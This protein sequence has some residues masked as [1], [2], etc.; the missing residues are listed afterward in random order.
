MKN[1]F[2]KI[3]STALIC[4]FS[5]QA[6]AQ[7]VDSRFY[8]WTVY[9]L[10]EDELHDKQCYIVS[11]PKDS[12]TDHSIRQKP[13]I[14]IA[15]FQRERKEEVSVYGG[16]EYK[17][18]SKIFFVIDD[19]DQYRFPTKG[20]VAWPRSKSEDVEVIQKMLNSSVVRVR[21]DSTIGTFAIDEYSTKGIAKAYSRMREI[22]K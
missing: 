1:G 15:R 16:Y 2:R 12:D 20:D 17:I 4:L 3:A 18:N 10:Q 9:E 14:M 21:S 6:V 13:Y 8:N 7:I 11:H 22:C 19:E 5:T